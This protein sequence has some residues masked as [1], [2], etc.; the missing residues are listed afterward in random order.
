MAWLLACF[1]ILQNSF[2]LRLTITDTE[3]TLLSESQFRDSEQYSQLRNR[4]ND[5][6]SR[7]NRT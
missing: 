5:S 7:N 2:V 1:D 4:D 6:N 3:R